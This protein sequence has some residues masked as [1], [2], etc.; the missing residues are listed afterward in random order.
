MRMG[1]VYIAGIGVHLPDRYSAE[2]AVAEGR[3]DAEV[4]ESTG[5]LSVSVAGDTPAP[6]LAI[7]AGRAALR[8][9]NIRAEDFAVLVH[10]HSHFQGPEIW[11]AHHYILNNT[12]GLPIPALSLSQGCLASVT[13]LSFV[14]S[15]LKV[16]TDKTAA[17]ITAADNFGTPVIDRWR[18]MNLAPLGDGGGAMVLSTES[19]FARLLSNGAHSKPMMEGLHRGGEQ[20]F[21]PPI[22]VGEP[23]DLERRFAYWN[24]QW[25]QGVKP[26]T[27]DATENVR[28]SVAE[29]LADADLKM[30]DITRV[31][32]PNF[33]KPAMCNFFLDPIDVE[34]ERGTYEFGR[35]VGHVGPVDSIAGLEHLWR[36]GQVR[37]GDIVLLLS[38]T[39]GME[40]GAVLVEITRDWKEQ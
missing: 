17:L 6:D 15:F 13:A 11:S 5:M 16:G 37:A 24:Q 19:G 34:L 39:P 31:V 12:V 30:G 33:G 21:P 2:Q 25:A 35:R 32:Q 1:D 36:T 22:T 29:A 28:E 9:A 3:Y 27:G 18:A 20:M 40:A 4:C 38:E 14:R 23:V 10:T 7:T 8:M 26:P